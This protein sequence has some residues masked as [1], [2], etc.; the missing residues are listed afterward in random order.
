MIVIEDNGKNSRKAG[1]CMN[2][3]WVST[4]PKEWKVD[5]AKAKKLQEEIESYEDK[6]IKID[7][8]KINN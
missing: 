3:F 2:Y 5:E 6:E 4:N 1:G 7:Y 8:D